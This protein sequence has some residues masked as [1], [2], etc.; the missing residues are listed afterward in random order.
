L[1]VAS[2]KRGIFADAG[3]TD[4]VAD[5]S[6]QSDALA[7]MIVEAWADPSFQNQ[8]TQGSQATRESNAKAALEARGIFLQSPI[9]ITEAEYE[10]GYHVPDPNKGVVLVLPNQP[11][12]E[13]PPAHQSLLETA[14]LLMACTPNGI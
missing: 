1:T 13:T 4:R 8:L 6:Y 10:G 14:K 12:T 9:V 2:K 7:Q 5:F 3:L 11:R